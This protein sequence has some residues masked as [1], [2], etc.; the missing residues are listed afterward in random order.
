LFRVVRLSPLLACTLRVP[1]R[2]GSPSQVS[3]ARLVNGGHPT[4]FLLF[5]S[6]VDFSVI[7]L[8]LN[9]VACIPPRPRPLSRCLFSFVW[10]SRVF[11]FSFYAPST[12]SRIPCVCLRPWFFF[13]LTTRPFQVSY[14]SFS[15]CFF[16]N[17]SFFPSKFGSPLN[18]VRPFDLVVIVPFTLSATA[19]ASDPPLVS[20][21]FFLSKYRYRSV[22]FALVCQ[23]CTTLSLVLWAILFQP[24]IFFLYASMFVSLQP[25]FQMLIFEC[26]SQH[27]QILREVAFPP[28]GLPPLFSLCG[29]GGF[30]PVFSIL[31][32]LVLPLLKS[33]FSPTTN[34]SVYRSA[35]RPLLLFAKVH[36][37]TTLSFAP[38]LAS[39]DYRPDYSQTVPSP[40]FSFATDVRFLAGNF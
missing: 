17:H 29:F 5:L 35:T 4:R 3:R 13:H 19:P 15:W 40:L 1:N 18:Q 2:S 24:T 9:F 23:V 33:S 30:F 36:P 39:L 34:S 38:P 14:R 31:V 10:G 21:F 28:K 16:S 27:Q 37:S 20:A 32:L 25:L 22:S 11:F 26:Y 7:V 12:L 6:I 8:T